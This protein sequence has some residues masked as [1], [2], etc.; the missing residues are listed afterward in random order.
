MSRWEG[1]GSYAELRLWGT[2]AVLPALGRMARGRRSLRGTPGLRFAKL[3]GTGSGDTFSPRDADPHHWALL[4]VWADEATRADFAASR[5][6]RSWQAAATEELVVSLTP[7]TSRGLW[8]GVQPFAGNPPPTTE[9]D[10]GR[11]RGPVAAIT[12]ARLRTLRSPSFHRAVP[13]VAD[14]LRTA[15]GLRASVGI[16][17]SPVGLQGTFSVWESS[18]ALVG[19]AYRSAA[20][21]EVVR[22]TDPARWYAEEMFARFAVTDLS[23]TYR[24]GTP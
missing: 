18:D 6:V 20:H 7:L 17:E 3:L 8:S 19:F 2:D 16:G 22:R 4:T 15:E 5:V 11:W 9:A 24:G 23:G 21:R 14:D 13:P 12:R 1:G 10:G